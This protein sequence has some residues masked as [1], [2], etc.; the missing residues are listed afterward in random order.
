MASFRIAF[1]GGQD[2]VLGT[3]DIIVVTTGG[4]VQPQNSGTR[5]QDSDKA[6][7]SGYFDKLYVTGAA[8]WIQV[9]G[10]GGGGG[11]SS[12]LTTKGDLYGFDTDNARIPV[13]S[14]GQVLTADSAQSLG[15]KWADSAAGCAISD[16]VEAFEVDSY[17]DLMPVI[18]NCVNDTMWRLNSDNSLSLRSNHFRYNWGAA[19]FTEDV[20]F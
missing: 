5:Q 11:D 15:V 14:D 20:S 1:T 3:N 12:P 7:G 2:A 4:S 16:W 13:G 18:S 9:T 6:W 17:G 10:A 19:A 8:G